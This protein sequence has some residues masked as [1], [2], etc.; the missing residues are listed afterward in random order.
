MKKTF[1]NFIA[2]FSAF[3]LIALTLT[4]CSSADVQKYKISS[5]NVIS[6]QNAGDDYHRYSTDNQLFVC[7]SGLIELYFDK[8]TYSI[9]VKDTS[10]GTM[11]YSL[12]ADKPDSSAAVLEATLSDENGNIYNFNSQDNSV[13]FDSASFTPAEDGISVTYKLAQTAETASYDITELKKDTPAV[14]VTVKYTLEDGS[15]LAQISR[16]DIVYPENISVESVSLLGYFSG[17]PATQSGD[18]IFIPDGCG[19]TVMTGV[20]DS[21]NKSYSIPVYGSDAG[22]AEQKSSSEALVPAF[23]MKQ[24][25]ASFVSLIE[26]GDTMAT[27]NAYRGADETKSGRVF[28]SFAVSDMYYK[29]G[30]NSSYTVYKGGQS[31]SDIKM[32]Y[33]FLSGKNATY[34]GFATACRELLI[35]NTVLS[36]ST[37][38]KSEY[39]P[40]FLTVDCAS[41]KKTGASSYTPLTTF[42][43]AE[44]MLTQMKAKGINN[45]FVKLSG[46]LGGADIQHDA[47]NIKLISALGG[48]DDYNKLYNFINIQQMELYLDVSILS[49]AKG[50]NGFS[51]SETAQTITG[52][53]I[54][55]SKAKSFSDISAKTEEKRTYIKES[56]LENEVSSLLKATKKLP[57]TGYSVNDYGNTLYSDYASDTGRDSLAKVITS[58]NSALATERKLMVTKGY[59][60]CLKSADV[61]CNMPSTTGNKQSAGYVAVPFIQLVLHGIADYSFEPINTATDTDTAFLK[62]MEYGALPSFEWYY[63]DTES[64]TLDEVYKYEN[65]MLKASQYYTKASVM[66]DTRSSRMTSHQAI[67]ENV[68]LTQF[69]NGVKVYVNYNDTAVEVND[70][71]IGAKSF[72][73]VG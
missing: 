37:V 1:R 53:D 15:L 64:D 46:A 26:S 66:N 6:A 13:A 16:G 29:Q 4:G 5:L 40:L 17:N 31:G 22:K 33:R 65:S 67:K 63:E 44:D 47:A 72:V 41:V 48:T 56:K 71:Y 42:E 18:F 45:I 36:T 58:T 70:I 61:V 30:R 50:S 10:V 43:E 2:V 19:A 73:K 38:E 69:S 23:G 68:Y 8:A 55:S 14:Q 54:V 11:W 57:L 25:N 28:A 24:G 39:Y 3:T 49:S 35:R 51:G 20:A 21:E 32:C 34:S 7:K 62:C 9:A 52:A 27:V 12:P 59:F 60:N